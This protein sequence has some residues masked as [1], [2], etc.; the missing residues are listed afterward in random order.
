MGAYMI[1]ALIEG[2]LGLV[3]AF[4]LALACPCFLAHTVKVTLP[5]KYQSLENLPSGGR[6]LGW[7]ESL[8]FFFSFWSGDYLIAGGWLT[9]KLG[10]K[11]ASWQHVI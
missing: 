5:P 1:T 11:W 4:L 6:Q 9:F 2:G 3:V 8:L 10:A 7:L